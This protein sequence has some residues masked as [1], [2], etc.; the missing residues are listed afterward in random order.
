VRQ[1]ITLQAVERWSVMKAVI[2]LIAPGEIDLNFEGIPSSFHKFIVR[3]SLK[4]EKSKMENR[5]KFI[6][7]VATSL[8]AKADFLMHR[9]KMRRSSAGKTNKTISTTVNCS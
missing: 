9:P 2:S 5:N 3:K 1:D 4:K 7:A 8:F 6:I